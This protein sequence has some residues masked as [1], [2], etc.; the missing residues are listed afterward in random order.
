[1]TAVGVSNGRSS[2]PALDGVRAVAEIGVIASHSA[3]LG[4]GWVGVDIFVGLSGYLIKGILMDA[5]VP[6]DSARD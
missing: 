6:A 2:V 4:L 3:I 1:M 5:K